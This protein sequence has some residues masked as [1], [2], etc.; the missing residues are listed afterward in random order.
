MYFRVN[1]HKETNQKFCHWMVTETIECNNVK[2]VIL[3]FHHNIMSRTFK[4]NFKCFCI[5]WHLE[6]KKHITWIPRILTYWIDVFIEKAI[7]KV[8]CQIVRIKE[9]YKLGTEMNNLLAE[10]QENVQSWDNWSK[11]YQ[12]PNQIIK[13]KW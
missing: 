13:K 4:K 8:L 9:N 6:A 5:S 12:I 11:I 7:L 2:L 10:R 1:H 3:A